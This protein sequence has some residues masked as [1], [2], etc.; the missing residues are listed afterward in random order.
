M[1]IKRTLFGEEVSITLTPAEMAEAYQEYK[2]E[3]ELQEVKDTLSE[4]DLGEVLKSCKFPYPG[5]AYI[6]D[7]RIETAEEMILE[8]KNLL[9]AIYAEFSNT[10]EEAYDYDTAMNMACEKKLEEWGKNHP[11]FLEQFKGIDAIAYE[12]YKEAWVK[13]R[14]YSPE[15]LA[16]IQ[17]AYE[18]AVREFGSPSCLEEYIDEHGYG[19]ECYVCFEEF[20]GAEY[21]DQEYMKELLTEEEYVKYCEDIVIGNAIETALHDGYDQFVIEDGGNGFGFT[22]VAD[23]KPVTPILSDEKVIGKVTV[24]YENGCR[25]ANYEEFSV[26]PSLAEKQR[27]MEIVEQAF[28]LLDKEDLT[29]EMVDEAFGL[30]GKVFDE[31]CLEQIRKGFEDGL[32]PEQVSIYAKP[33][34]T[35]GQMGQV[36][37]GLE[38]GLSMEQMSV[39]VNHEFDWKQMREIREGFEHGLSMEQVSVYANHEFTGDQMEEIRDGFEHGLSMEQVSV[40]AKSEF[41]WEQMREIRVGFEQGLSMEQMSVYAK[42]EFIDGQ[43]DQIRC[44]FE[45]GLTSEQVAVYAKP[46]FTWRQMNE[47][48]E[49]FEQGLSMEQVSVYANHEF[50]WEQMEEIRKGFEHSLSMEQVSPSIKKPSLVEKIMAAKKEQGQAVSKEPEKSRGNEELAK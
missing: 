35:E 25:A 43:M 44:G 26:E 5:H 14:N 4:W 40:Y 1:E 46:E 11:D 21:Q 9:A 50:T 27:E 41:T 15:F 7:E 38:N 32:T 19:G 28:L 13:E 12:K 34:F 10:N 42:P 2:E 17:E 36:R 39:Y 6:L 30:L 47:I 8:D 20:L 31:D 23:G 24:S 48:R 45:A 49:G 22:R 18:E 16:D 33:E 29:D 37:L 3:L